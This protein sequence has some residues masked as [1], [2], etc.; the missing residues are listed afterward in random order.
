MIGSHG[1]RET[2]KRMSHG[3]GNGNAVGSTDRVIVT[4]K[5]T[6]ELPKKK[7]QTTS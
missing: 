3:C 4:P 6:E 2:E 7:S 1:C 5:D